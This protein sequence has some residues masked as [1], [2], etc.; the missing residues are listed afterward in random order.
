MIIGILGIVIFLLLVSFGLPIMIALFLVSTGGLIYLVGVEQTLAVSAPMFYNYISKYEFS[1]IPMFVLMGYIGFHS[2]L[3][4]EIF[5]VSRMW[6]GRLRAGLAMSVVAAQVIFGACSGSTVSACVVIGKSAIP[7]MRRMGY[8][9]ALATGVVAGSGTLAALIPPSVTICIY[10][11]LVDESIGKL[12]IG[13]VLPGMLTAAIYIIML[14]IRSGNVKRDTARY[15]LRE[16][17]FALR[18]LWVV[19]ALIL[20]IMGGIYGGVCTPTEAGAFGAFVMFILALATGRVN[21]KMLW[22]SVSS[23]VITT[24]MILIIIISAVLFARF[25]TLSGFSRGITEWLTLLS[26]PR[27]V[28]FLIMVAIYLILG[29]FV[30]ATGMMVM[31]LPT[32]YPIMMDLGY[33][34]IWFGITVVI[35]CELAVETPPVGVNLYATQSVAGDVPL[36][37]V[38]RGTI[39]FVCRDLMAL[40][41]LYL[42]P[43]I[44]TFLPNTM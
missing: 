39:P 9:D 15:T 13:G 14:V 7:V 28:I 43:G 18:Y 35:L 25:L 24:G 23:T 27:V 8:P 41:V 6:L 30:G 42:F 1:V 32:F 31:T 36:T 17:I 26:V 40:F 10:G 44:A 21:M 34:P 3:F 4:S 12:L 29:C 19:V 37:T 11:L 38:I 5:E 20:A 16:K 2:G 22:E 33:D